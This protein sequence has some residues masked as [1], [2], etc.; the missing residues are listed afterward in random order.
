MDALLGAATETPI[1]VMRKWV[2]RLRSPAAAGEASA[3]A[4]H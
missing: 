3:S 1:A 4:V 2:L